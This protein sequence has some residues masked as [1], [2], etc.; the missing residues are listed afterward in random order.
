MWNRKELKAKGKDAF[1]AN[2]WRS[3]LVAL[4]LVAFTGSG[5]GIIGGLSGGL[6][7]DHVRL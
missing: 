7:G 2:Y 4:V 5:A 3:V 6:G 1:Q